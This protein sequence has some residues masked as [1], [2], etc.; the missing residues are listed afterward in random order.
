MGAPGSVNRR[1]FLGVL[2][3]AFAVRPVKAAAVIS[4]FRQTSLGYYAAALQNGLMSLD[5]VRALESLSPI[6]PSKFAT[7]RLN[8]WVSNQKRAPHDRTETP[9]QN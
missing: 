1:G 7:H 6:I 4:P 8:A 5:E 2:A 9:C 3:A